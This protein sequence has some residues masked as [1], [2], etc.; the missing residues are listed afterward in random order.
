[1]SGVI[2]PA[3][4]ITVHSEARNM[5]QRGNDWIFSDENNI[6]HFRAAGV[7]IRDNKLFVQKESNNVCAIPGGHVSFGETSENALIREFKEEIGIDI[8]VDRL[9]WVEENFWKW[10]TKDAH[11]ISFYFLVSLSNDSDLADSFNKPIK[12]HSDINLQWVTFDEIKELEIYPSYIKDKIANISDS[13]EHFTR[14]T[15]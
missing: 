7:L 13:M 6:C 5:T 2:F 1:M 12:D 9:I 4:H 8:V 3:R 15:W 10:G 14:N 11:N